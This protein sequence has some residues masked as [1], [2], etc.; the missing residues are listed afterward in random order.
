VRN[1]LVRQR[2]S[3]FYFEPPSEYKRWRTRRSSLAERSDPNGNSALC[4]RPKHWNHCRFRCRAGGLA[5]FL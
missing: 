1:W 4:H 3:Q 5:G 2:V